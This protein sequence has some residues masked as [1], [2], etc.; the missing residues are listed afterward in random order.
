MGSAAMGRA[1]LCSTGAWVSDWLVSAERRPQ[2]ST[3][4]L[5]AAPVGL[6]PLDACSRQWAV[7]AERT[8][9]PRVGVAASLRVESIAG[10]VPPFA[11]E[12]ISRG[13][14]EKEIVSAS[15]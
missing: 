9:L 11:S 15:G 12:C 3:R 7:R 10:M 4:S 8:T 6:V 14:E 13:S 1:N 2:A 5:G